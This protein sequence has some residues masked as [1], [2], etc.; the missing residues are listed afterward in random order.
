M[1]VGFQFRTDRAQR[2][3]KQE[4]HQQNYKAETQIHRSSLN[5]GRPV[6]EFQLFRL[7]SSGKKSRSIAG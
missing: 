1:R 2:Q 4:N 7:N 5:F 3:H 6:I